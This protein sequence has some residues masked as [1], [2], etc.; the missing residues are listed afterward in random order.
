MSPWT[1]MMSST[2]QAIRDEIGAGWS[3]LIWGTLATM[4]PLIVYVR[5]L[6]ATIYSGDSG[7]LVTGAYCLGIVHPPGYP[8]YCLLGRLFALLPMGSVAHRLNFFSSLCAALCAGLVFLLTRG[9]V[10]RA[11]RHHRPHR[12]SADRSVHGG[13]WI[14][15]AALLAALACAFSRTLWTQAVVAEVYA[16]NL[17]LLLLCGA[18]LLQWQRNGQGRFLLLFAF[19]YGLSLAHHSSA[20][21]TAP[22]FLVFLAWHRR[23]LFENRR[24]PLLMFGLV[25]LGLT[26]YLYL[27]LRALGRPP[28]DWGH[29]VAPGEVWA[30]ITRASYGSLSTHPRSLALLGKQVLAWLGLLA[31]QMGRGWLPLAA[32]GLIVLFRRLRDWGVFTLMLFLIVGLGTIG[33]LNFPV[34]SRE[35]YL[36]RVFFIPTFAVMALWV[37][38]GMAWL[39]ERAMIWANGR[40]D[41]LRVRSVGRS[42]GRSFRRS[43]GLALGGL[44]P[45]LAIFPVWR[46]F[47]VAD[48]SRERM[49]AR[50]GRNMLA[51]MEPEAILFT[52]RDTP[53]F[54]VAHARIVEGLRPDVSLKHTGPADIF[55]WLT[56]PP[57]PADPRRRPLYGTVP[58]ELPDI[59]GWSPQ[60]L[61]ML[62]QLR[63]EPIETSRL[64]NVWERCRWDQPDRRRLREDFLLRELFYNVIAARGNLA[65]ELARRG[66]FDL[67]LQQA[68]LAVAMDSTFYGSHLA[69]GDVYFLQGHYRAA[70]ESYRAARRLAPERAEIV[71]HLALAHLRAGLFARAAELYHE[72]LALQPGR[73]HIYNELG[74][75]LKG[76]GRYREAADA[77]RRA[78]ELDARFPDP[79]RNLGVLLA[80]RLGDAAGAVDLWERYLQL[81]PDDPEAASIRSEIER[82]RDSSEHEHDIGEKTPTGEGGP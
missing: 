8:I 61:G 18:S 66:E 49:V 76:A 3:V 33:L 70:I 65:E 51:T 72:S 29:P 56:P 36:V 43:V 7:E 75:A 35:L 16:L 4:I 64:L 57:V 77:Y 69:T 31:E 10:I 71:D 1:V 79:L 5:T 45:L 58:E 14:E 55:R 23:Q 59:P 60:G 41:H 11:H 27:P 21:L 15:G 42:V 17:L 46:N 68:T 2:K 20:L 47:A 25:I 54:A 40:G 32:V 37:G 63:K 6:C 50:L 53:T 12:R 34:T 44:F 9:L 39:A 80:Y 82:L 73:A 48:H 28:L 81:R 13:P 26:P 67:A 78:I 38:L 24:I 30:H 52:S 62:Y 74:L 19:I 22:A